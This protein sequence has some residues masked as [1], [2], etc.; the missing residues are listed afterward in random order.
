MASVR[1]RVQGTKVTWLVDYFDQEGK[2]HNK[3]FTSKLRH[4]HIWLDI[5]PY[6]VHAS[7][8]WVGGGG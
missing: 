5:V 3:T 1:K 2:R 4:S 6:G 8:C 7:R